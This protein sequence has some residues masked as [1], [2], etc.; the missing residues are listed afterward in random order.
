M[1]LLQSI[2]LAV[3]Q[4][5]AEFLPISSSAH[6]VLVPYIFG[7]D[8]KGLGFDVALHFGT[9]LA[10]VIYFWRDWLYIIQN[11]FADRKQQDANDSANPN[12]LPSNILWQILI[13]TIP[14]GI[15]GYF[16]ADHVEEWFHS[17]ILIAI[18]LA[19]FGYILWK[20]DQ[21]AKDSLKYSDINWKRSF[22]VGLAQCLALVPGVSRSG[23]TI[24]TSRSLG[25]KRAEA[26]KFSF[27]LGTPAVIGAFLVSLRDITLRDLDI[28]FFLSVILSAIVGYLAIKYLLSYLST[29]DMRVFMNYR[30]VLALIILA[31]YLT[32]L[33]T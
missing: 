15:F 17:P 32:A 27:L 28:F 11:A 5:I 3:I 25:L 22:L 24:L 31:V 12:Y 19:V 6:L 7:W 23:I 26:A 21:K 13:A 10:V 20:V 33:Y 16:L 30:F 14:A 29:K 1:E 18:N 4:G 9:A 2:I 8:Y